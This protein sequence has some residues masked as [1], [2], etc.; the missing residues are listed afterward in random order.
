MNDHVAQRESSNPVMTYRLLRAGVALGFR[1]YDAE[2]GQFSGT[3][4]LDSR[5]RTSTC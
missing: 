2:T 4:L 5:R 3:A 1:D